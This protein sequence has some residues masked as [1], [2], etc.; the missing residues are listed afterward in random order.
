MRQ[1]LVAPRRMQGRR[2]SDRHFAVL[3][4]HDSGVAALAIALV[5]LSICDAF[6]TLTLISRGG[7][8]LN[9]F[10]NWMLQQGV[11]EFATAKMLLTALP[12]LLLVATANLK[13]FS[14]IRARSILATLVG[15]YGGLIC[16]E[17]L[18]LSAG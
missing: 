15:L 9:P 16:Y 12:A 17:L 7:S 8:E 2:Q 5:L 3:D 1:S 11:A 13:F 4:R 18:L 6:F 10:M 14:W